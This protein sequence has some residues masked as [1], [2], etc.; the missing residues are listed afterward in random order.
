VRLEKSALPAS[1]IVLR[2]PLPG[3]AKQKHAGM[4]LTLL[5]GLDRADETVRQR[6]ESSMS[7]A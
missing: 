7:P 4:M 3:H 1:V 5:I 2:L 6:N